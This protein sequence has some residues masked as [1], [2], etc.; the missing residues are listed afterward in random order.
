[1][2]GLTQAQL[3][4]RVHRDQTFV[5]NYESGERRLDILEL[6]EVC[7]ATEMDLALFI[8]RLDKGWDSLYFLRL[9]AVAGDRLNH[10]PQFIFQETYVRHLCNCIA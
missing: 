5:S 1:M 3:A 2:R 9:D 7:C 6:R 4:A 10:K 8:R